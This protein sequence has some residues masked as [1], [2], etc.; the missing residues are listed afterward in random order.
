V[1]NRQQS[2][3][4]AN[5]NHGLGLG[6]RH[7]RVHRLLLQG[8]GELAKEQRQDVEEVQAGGECC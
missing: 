7:P 1:V 4:I 3:F 5:V 6:S 2:D 8:D